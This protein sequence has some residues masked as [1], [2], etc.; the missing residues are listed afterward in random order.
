MT[1]ILMLFMLFERACASRQINHK[2]LTRFMDL[3][4]RTC[5]FKKHKPHQNDSHSLSERMDLGSSN[6]MMR[7]TMTSR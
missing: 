5:A 6:L 7:L 4:A 3:P 2:A 1:I